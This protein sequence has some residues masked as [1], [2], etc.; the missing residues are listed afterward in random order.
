M[1]STCRVRGCDRPTHGTSFW[2]EP[3]LGRWERT[4]DVHA[5]IPIGGRTDCAV[6]G[7]DE[8]HYALGWCHI[9][10]NR[11]RLTGRLD[12]VRPEDMSLAEWNR[13]HPQPPIPGTPNC[14]GECNLN[15]RLTDETVAEARQAYRDG[16]TLTSLAKRYEIHH[17]TL[18]LAV[19]GITWSHVPGAVTPDE[20]AAAIERLRSHAVSRRTAK[21]DPAKARTV[22]WLAAHGATRQDLSPVADAWGVHVDT[23]RSVI[24]RYT[25]NDVT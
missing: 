25:W 22:R 6:A 1:A 23:F 15:A 3:H 16:E 5:D 19:R 10:Y 24:L 20:A 18:S 8:P 7:C 4:G 9:H 12:R 11:Q 13:L 21:L 2:C 14:R 17:T